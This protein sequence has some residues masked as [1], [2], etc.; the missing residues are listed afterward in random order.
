MVGKLDLEMGSNSKNVAAENPIQGLNPFL[1]DIQNEN[2]TLQKEFEAQEYITLQ[3]LQAEKL[4]EEGNDIRLLH[5]LNDLRTDNKFKEECIHSLKDA[6][7]MNKERKLN[8]FSSDSIDEEET[9]CPEPTDIQ[10]HK[11]FQNKVKR[12]EEEERQIGASK[13]KI[14][15]LKYIL[16]NVEMEIQNEKKKVDGMHFLISSLSNDIGIRV[17]QIRRMSTMKYR[18]HNRYKGYMNSYLNLKNDPIFFARNEQ[19]VK[20]KEI[21]KE[22]KDW[23]DLL[24]RKDERLKKD[25]ALYSKKIVGIRRRI[26][27]HQKDNAMLLEEIENVPEQKPIIADDKDL[28]ARMEVLKS[29][30]KFIYLLYPDLWEKVKA[31]LKIKDTFSYEED[32]QKFISIDLKPP[33]EVI[34][35]EDKTFL[36]N[37][38]A[39]DPNMLDSNYKAA[40]PKS[41]KKYSFGLRGSSQNSERSINSSISSSK[42]KPTRSKL[43]HIEEETE[44]N[45]VLRHYNNKFHKIEQ[46]VIEAIERKL[47]ITEDLKYIKI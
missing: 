19:D 16:E 5:Y 26:K 9:I 3:Q 15:S 11:F 30:K 8:I 47:D 23:V 45:L 10:T 2:S 14:N 21:E 33:P 40:S 35:T 41:L 29:I 43:H 24:R 31:K 37:S 34:V 28:K 1:D 25:I 22:T 17:D 6:L 32:H 46:E 18:I 4:L 39:K 27:E 7:S 20:V 13:S 42:S 36:L 44:L 12:L 38:R